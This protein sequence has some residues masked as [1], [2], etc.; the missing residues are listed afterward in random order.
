MN[1]ARLAYI[2]RNDIFLVNSNNE[3]TNNNNNN[4]IFCFVP[5]IVLVLYLLLVTLL[6]R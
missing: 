1:P 4:D 6:V 5:G 3:N 2:S